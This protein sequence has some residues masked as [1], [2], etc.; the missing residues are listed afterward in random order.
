MV[1]CFI[2]DGNGHHLTSIQ[3]PL[4]DDRRQSFQVSILNNSISSSFPSCPTTEPVDFSRAEST[5]RLVGK[6]LDDKDLLSDDHITSDDEDD[7]DD[8]GSE[9]SEVDIVGDGKSY[10]L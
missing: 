8:E 6:S 2:K 9:T 4:R 5:R 10:M 1:G 7:M 3:F